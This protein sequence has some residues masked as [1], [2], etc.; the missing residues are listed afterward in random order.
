MA[1]VRL[2]DV[3]VPVKRR[4]RELPRRLRSLLHN[5]GSTLGRLLIVVEG[6]A[7]ESDSTWNEW[8]RSEPRCQLLRGARGAGWVDLCNLGLAERRGDA[9]ILHPDALVFPGWLDALAAVARSAER[10]ALA[11]PLGEGD[12]LSEGPIDWRLFQKAVSGLP[13]DTSLPRAGL[14]CNC[15]RGDILDAVGPLDPTFASPRA[16]LD[17][18]ATRA[19]NLGFVARRANH[20]LVS[21]DG[22][23]GDDDWTPGPEDIAELNARHPRLADRVARFE[24]TL[25]ATLARRA[26]DI[27]TSGKIRVALDL[28]HISQ[29]VNGTKNYAAKL[30]KALAAMPEVELTLVATHPIQAEGIPG[31]LARPD[32]WPD[33]VDVIHKTA[34]VFDRRHAK[35]LFESSAHVVLTYQDLIAYRLPRVFD[36][37][38]DYTVYQNT[39]RITVLAAQAVLAYSDN[40]V[41]EIEAE[42]GIP[43]EDIHGILLGVDVEEFSRPVAAAG[44]IRK[45]LR[46]PERYLFSVAS[47]YPHKNLSGLLEAYAKFRATRP[48]G[49]RPALVLAGSAPKVEDELEEQHEGGMPPGV[50]FLGTVS[51]DELRVL[52]Q[53]AEAFVYSSLYEGFGLPPLE[54]MA[55]GA[56]VVAMR[57]SSVP[58]V[59]GDAALYA[60]GLSSDDL[61]LALER[62]VDDKALRRDLRERGRKRAEELDWRETARRTVEVY[63]RIILNPSRRSLEMRRSLTAAIVHWADVEVPFALPAAPA[64][65][66]KGAEAAAERGAAAEPAPVAEQEPII[67]PEPEIESKDVVEQGGVADAPA[68]IVAMRTPP[69][70]SFQEAE[71][72]GIINAWRALGGAVRRRV[73]RDLAHVPGFERIWGSRLNRLSRRFVQVARTDGL[74]A[75]SERALRKARARSTGAPGVCPPPGQV[76]RPACSYFQPPKPRDRY[77]AWRGANAPNPRRS[78]RLREAIE[79]IERPT[80]FSI[81]VPVYNTPVKFLAAAID[82]ALAQSYENWELILVDDASTDSRVTTYLDEQLPS[83][84]RVRLIRRETNGNISAAT[85]TAAEHARGEFLVL[86]DHD[87]VLHPDAL[88]HLA[89]HINANPKV[90]LIYTD[91]DKL[92]TD[93]RRMAPQFKPDWSPELLLSFCYTAHLT[94][95]R[96]SLYRRVGGMRLGFEGSQDHDFWLRASELAREIGHI[97][98][99][100]YHWRVLPG[101]TAASG[102]EK[103]QSFEAGRRAVEEAFGRRGVSCRVKRPD[104]AVAAGCGIYEPVMSDDGPSVAILVPTKNRKKLL[105]TLLTSLEKT[106]YRNYRVYIIDN[107]SDDPETLAYLSASPHR[108]LRI[109]NP[110]GRFNYAAIHNRAVSMLTEELVLFINN[111]VEVINPRWLSQMV[112]WSRLPGVGSVG[113]RLLYTDRRLQ[114]AGVVHGL[115]EGLAGHAFKLL[116]WWDGGEMGLARVTRDCLAVTAACML[117]PRRLFVEMGGFDEERFAVAYN[118]ADYGYRLVDAGHRNVICAEAELYHHEGAT[119]GFVDN[120]LEEANYRKLH[121][122]RRDPYFNPHLDTAIE[123]FQLKPTVVPIAPKDRPIPVLAV[124][125][126]LNFEGAPRFELEL[127]AGLKEAGAIEPTVI[128]P[129]DGPLR[130]EYEKAGIHPLIDPSLAALFQNIN[131]YHEIRHRT[132]DWIAREGFEV[133]HANTLHGFWA[134]DAAR[135]AGVG[136]VWSVHESEAWHGYFDQF[137]T[138]VAREALAA[139]SHP[140]RMVFSARSTADLWRPL[141]SNHGFELIRY[142]LDVERF[143]RKLDEC[144]R[145]EAREQ[146]DLAPDEVCVLLLGTVCDRKGQH[147]LLHAFKR[148]DDRLVGAT[149]CVV[150]GARDGL[151]YSRE[152]KRLASQ[153]DPDR[154]D[155]FQIVDETGDT[156][157]YWRAADIF[158]CASRNESYPYVILEAMGRGLPIITTPVFGISEQVRPDVNA[159]IYAPWDIETLRRHL[160]TLIKDEALRRRMAEASSHVLQALPSHVDKLKRYAD[161]FRAAA[162]SGFA[163]ERPAA[164]SFAPSNGTTGQAVSGG[165]SRVGERS[166]MQLASRGR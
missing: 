33:D 63:R 106:T 72:M 59:C 166:E 150:V 95:T 98:Q 124:S 155:R 60:K 101:S 2:V 22:S 116:P 70:C 146:L 133:V 44:E 75:A 82:G 104:W 122:D 61:A 27:Q 162:E 119:R 42:F 127:I 144:S 11:A 57:A 67:V 18:W 94:A 78:E 35:R 25:D 17:D 114:H 137:P 115:H 108:V 120:P 145:D 71:P 51:N 142:G 109:K 121:G 111:D 113:A 134:V 79:S 15:L 140:Y 40:T 1:R 103:P 105:Q 64:Q 151:E 14:I 76:E 154:R 53:G 68:P 87:D 36:E 165:W 81:L 152:L 7:A 131:A 29:D 136:S 37:E 38:A 160:E 141:D 55:A 100:L 50:Q 84:S 91:D 148:L 88:A 45:R 73:R 54:A 164:E 52:Y 34:Q 90:D 86:L 5:A 58:E 97:P 3:I 69:A 102:N 126:N 56:P 10:V 85:N 9:V 129:L 74:R 159:L 132:A 47:D 41:T 99:I 30:G 16:A 65:P 24:R 156:A 26:V 6:A 21:L 130:A 77:E 28:R 139:M 12:G 62:I 46:L 143:G 32:D 39:S 23:R 13:A 43:R 89:I 112:G 49:D 138:E 107:E 19:R 118:D 31:R 66:L 153:L 110:D 8:V 161:L 128:S 96:A 20:V 48:E 163:A 4:G 158:C 125:H 80:M 92:G 93:G 149:R 123:S 117:T 135:T 83:D 147:D 157:R